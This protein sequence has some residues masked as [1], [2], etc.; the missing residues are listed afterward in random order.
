MERLRARQQAAHHDATRERV[1]AAL[2][3]TCAAQRLRPHPSLWLSRQRSPYLSPRARSPAALLPAST[4]FTSHQLPVSHLA[5]PTLR[6]QHAHR[7]QPHSATT[8]VS[9]Q[10]N[11]FLLTPVPSKDSRRCGRTSQPT[12]VSS[13]TLRFYNLFLPASS[14]RNHSSLREL[15]PLPPHP[16]RVFQ[17]LLLSMQADSRT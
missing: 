7:A 4:N 10:T 1:P 17:P 2:L 5:P 16:A 8:G 6:S 11:R 9:M 3:P 12:C 13:A 14:L 15:S